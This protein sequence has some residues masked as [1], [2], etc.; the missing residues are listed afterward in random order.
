MYEIQQATLKSCS[1]RT[2]RWCYLKLLLLIVAGSLQ[3]CE[4]ADGTAHH[5]KHCFI[6]KTYTWDNANA[7][8]KENGMHLATITNDAE[9]SEIAEFD[10]SQP[11]V[12]KV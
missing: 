10:P 1:V 2:A 11:W 5:G 8:C 7:I 3:H 9:N 4:N 6:Q 12:R